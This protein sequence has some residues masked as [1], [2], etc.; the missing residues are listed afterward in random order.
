[1]ATVRR[2]VRGGAGLSSHRVARRE[3]A[4]RGVSEP[5]R[6][7]VP[8][9]LRYALTRRH[10][11]PELFPWLP[12]LAG[13]LGF[14]I[15]AV[16]LAVDVSAWFLLLLLLPITLYSGLIALLFDLV[17]RARLPVEVVVDETTLDVLVGEDLRRL[18]LEGVIQVYRI[19]GTSDWALIHGDGPSLT[20]PAGAATAEQLDYLKGFARRAAAARKA[21]ERG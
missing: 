8:F 15:G 4:G 9:T 6:A 21:A 20:I 2:G 14:S 13:S 3:S 18:T 11:L 7:V 16:V 5:R 19:E 17:F 10:R 1:L 12:A